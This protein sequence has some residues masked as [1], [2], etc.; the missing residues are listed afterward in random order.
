[1]PL[2]NLFSDSPFS[3]ADGDKLPFTGAKAPIFWMLQFQHRTYELLKAMLVLSF[4]RKALHF[5]FSSHLNFIHYVS[6]YFYSAT[7][8][9]YNAYND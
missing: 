3:P 8:Y 6:L 5:G 9:S 1:M 2:S 7:T 4:H